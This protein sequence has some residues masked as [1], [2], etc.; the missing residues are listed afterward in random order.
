MIMVVAVVL[1]LAAALA[2][3]QVRQADHVK[4]L[5]HTQG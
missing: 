3:E 5:A 2:R 1:V 4:Q